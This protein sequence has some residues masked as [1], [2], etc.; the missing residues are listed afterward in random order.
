[1]RDY[2]I[3]LKITVNFIIIIL[4]VFLLVPKILSFF[5]PF[6]IGWIV[7]MIANPRVRFLDK[8]MKIHRKHSSAIIIV[9]VVAVIVGLSYLLFA[10]TA[11]EVEEPIKC[12]KFHNFTR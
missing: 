12:I 2:R 7:A 3:Y 1:M 5:L 9:I 8:R 10:V 11:K 6:V 4:V